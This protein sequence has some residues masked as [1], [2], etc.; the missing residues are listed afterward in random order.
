L[1][2]LANSSYRTIIE[3][4][5]KPDTDPGKAYETLK[6]LFNHTKKVYSQHE[7]FLS[8]NELGLVENAHI[9]TVR[10]ANMATFVTSV[11]GSQDVG[12]YHLNEYFLDTFMADGQKMLKTQAQ[13]FLDLKTQAYISALTSKDRSRQEILDDLFPADLEHR[14]LSR[15]PGAKQVAPSEQDFLQRARNRRKALLD[16]PD[17]EEASAALPEKYDWEDFVRNVS[18]WISRNFHTIA[19]GTVSTC[20]LQITSLLTHMPGS[21]D[22]STSGWLKHLSNTRKTAAK[23]SRS[24]SGP[25]RNPADAIQSTCRKRR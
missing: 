19:G 14:L 7:P 20:S 10:K 15:R 16:E 6:D 4:A 22:P 25:A 11:F 13:I 24:S 12:F 3:M 17:T 9:D 5:T 1:N 2:I 23:G 8:P 18:S 21:K